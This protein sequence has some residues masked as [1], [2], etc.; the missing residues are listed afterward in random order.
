MR[1]LTWLLT[2]NM[3]T[4]RA[5]VPACAAPDVPSSLTPSSLTWIG[6]VPGVA[7][8]CLGGGLRDGEG[9][10]GACCQFFVKDH[11]SGKEASVSTKNDMGM[12][13]RN[14]CGARVGNRVIGLG[15]RLPD[16]RDGAV[17]RTGE[18]AR[19]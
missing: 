3:A 17:H 2:R 11:C 7:T 13:L 19:A 15:G 4:S 6:A 8:Q 1:S 14:V 5:C 18:D 9:C 10:S 16:S 12:D